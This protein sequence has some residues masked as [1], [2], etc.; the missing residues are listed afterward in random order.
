M[1]FR[2]PVCESVEV[3]GEHLA[4]HLAFT[5]M[6]RGGGHE[7]WLEEHVAGWGELDPEGLAERVTEAVPE[8]DAPEIEG[9]ESGH[10]LGGREG[11]L[12]D[13]LA[14]QAGHRGPGRGDLSDEAAGVLAEAQALTAE[15]YGL[16]DEDVNEE[17]DVDGDGESS[18]SESE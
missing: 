1:A 3:D 14:R 13:E 12:E 4:N 6:L 15:M 16:D 17:E 2:C 9:D 5:A 7:V 11:R 10:D 8:V 18:E